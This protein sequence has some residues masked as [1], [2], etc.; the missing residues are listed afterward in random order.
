VF[1]IW[2]KIIIFL[3][4]MTPQFILS[5]LK[6][7]SLTPKALKPHIQSIKLQKSFYSSNFCSFTCAVMLWIAKFQVFFCFDHSHPC[8]C[9]LMKMLKIVCIQH[10]IQYVSDFYP[11]GCQIPSEEFISYAPSKIYNLDQPPN[12]N[13]QITTHSITFF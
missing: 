12:E 9:T 1:P 5:T 3:V 10:T 2:E 6:C 7:N 4:K 8:V 13:L 11:A